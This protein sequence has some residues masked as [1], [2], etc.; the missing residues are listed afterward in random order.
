MHRFIKELVFAFIEFIEHANYIEQGRFTGA[1]GPHDGDEFAF[2][3][4]QVDVFEQEH[5]VIAVVHPF[6]NFSVPA[7]T[8]CYSLAFNKDKYTIARPTLCQEINH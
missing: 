5:P 4:T 6:E 3:H 8:V 7:Y 1:G 2:L